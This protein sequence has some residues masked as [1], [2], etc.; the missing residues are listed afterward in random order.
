MLSR[1]RIDLS[2]KILL[3]V[4]N[5]SYTNVLEDKQ[6]VTQKLGLLKRLNSKE[7]RVCLQKRYAGCAA[8][9]VV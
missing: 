4:A 3:S 8:V 2:L 6:S 5:I 1:G 7:I 9:T